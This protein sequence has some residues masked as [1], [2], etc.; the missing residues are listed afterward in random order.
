MP[1][2]QDDAP[3]LP[4][5]AEDWPCGLRCGDCRRPL[6]HGDRYAERLTG[7]AGEFPVVVI[8]CCPCDQR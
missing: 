7:M 2:D 5:R 4:V 8:V 1:D 3:G 6:E